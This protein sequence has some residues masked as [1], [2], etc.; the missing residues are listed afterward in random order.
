MAFWGANL[1]PGQAHQVDG[2]GEVLHISGACLTEKAKPGKNYVKAKTADGTFTICAL[3]S[4]VQESVSLDLFLTS[5]HGPVVLRNEGESEVDLVGYF[6]PGDETM[7]ADMSDAEVMTGV[8]SD[9][10]DESASEDEKKPVQKEKK[11][12]EKKP[13]Q[14]EEK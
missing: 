14:K 6:E 5:S 11:P 3:S 8:P 13:A 9:D 1:K 7:D 12:V 4:G 2:E 10:E